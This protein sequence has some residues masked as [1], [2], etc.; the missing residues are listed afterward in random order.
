MKRH[1]PFL[2]ICLAL[3]LALYAIGRLRASG[4]YP[5]SLKR[6]LHGP[7]DVTYI[8]SP[9]IT[10]ELPDDGDKAS[11]M[12]W[13]D[14]KGMPLDATKG[15]DASRYEQLLTIWA[16]E[17]YHHRWVEW[18]DQ[19][20]GPQ[21]WRRDTSEHLN[22]SCLIGDRSFGLVQ[23][24]TWGGEFPA[25]PSSNFWTVTGLFYGY[26]DSER[27]IFDR[28]YYGI[29]NQFLYYMA[30]AWPALLILVFAPL[31]FFYFLHKPILR[32]LTFGRRLTSPT[33][34]P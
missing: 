23:L 22:L 31:T 24:R 12:R 28:D 8:V 21:H 26:D 5:D 29:T 25:S 19:N 7:Y 32:A 34:A 33:T 20:W 17:S 27:Y 4:G 1:L 16:P 18:L 15:E 2:G 14:E 13:L 6:P 3:F 30:P 9:S 11:L 10:E